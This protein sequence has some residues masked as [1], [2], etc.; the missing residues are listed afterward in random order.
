MVYPRYFSHNIHAEEN[1]FGS[2]EISEH[3]NGFNKFLKTI[4]SQCLSSIK[5]SLVHSQIL[6]RYVTLPCHNDINLK[7]DSTL[8]ILQKLINNDEILECIESDDGLTVTNINTLLLSKKIDKITREWYKRYKPDSTNKSEVALYKKLFKISFMMN[9]ISEIYNDKHNIFQAAYI[10]EIYGFRCT[11]TFVLQFTS[12]IVLSR[13][14]NFSD[15]I[16]HDNSELFLITMII[17]FIVGNLPTNFITSSTSHNILIMNT[18]FGMGYY[19]RMIFALMDI[20]INTLMIMFV[21]L[22]SASLLYG[23]DDA[24]QIVFSSVSIMFIS[25]LDDQAFSKSDSNRLLRAHELFAST[26]LENIDTMKDRK[27]I[28]FVQYVPWIE[29]VCMFLSAI[30]SIFY[31]YK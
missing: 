3:D 11:V 2:L 31:I 19:C 25:S 20:I 12:Y 1:I 18:L 16:Y 26:L 14:L 15:V 29:T 27:Y 8:S 21:P 5:M 4:L 28:K 24:L 9:H 6:R 17:V 10:D 7:N 22:F 13:E 30:S 23:S